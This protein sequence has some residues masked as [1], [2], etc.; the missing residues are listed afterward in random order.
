MAS[1]SRSWI[2]SIGFRVSGSGGGGISQITALELRVSGF[3][4]RVLGF[5]FRLSGFGFRGGFSE[6]AAQISIQYDAKQPRFRMFRD[7]VGGKQ[8]DSGARGCP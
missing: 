2:L 6:V 7:W 5:G 8:Q 3:D 4:F 1:G